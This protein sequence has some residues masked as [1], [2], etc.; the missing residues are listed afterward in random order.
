[1]KRLFARTILGLCVL[2]LSVPMLSAGKPLV[3]VD[4]VKGY[5]IE[6]YSF[7]IDGK[8][9]EFALRDAIVPEEEPVFESEGELVRA[10]EAK[11]QVLDNKRI[12]SDVSYTYELSSY[13][14]NIAYYAV[15]F[16]IVDAFTLLPIPYAKYDN[17]DIGL[18]FGVKL[19]NKNLFGT[20]ADLYM[21]GHISQGD[22]GAN[23]WDNREDYLELSVSSL[24]IGSSSLD[25]SVDYEYTNNS[26]DPGEFSFEVD[27]SDLSL[28]GVSL[29]LAPTGT[30]DLSSDFDTWDPS[31]FTLETTFGPFRQD[32]AL[33]SLYSDLEYTADTDTLYTYGYLK[34]HELALF[35][36]PIVF[37]FSV[38]SSTTLSDGPL[39]YLN[40]GPLLETDLSLP[41]DFT[42]S[43]SAGIFLHY[44]PYEDPLGYFHG[45][46]AS[47]SR[48]DIN[49][50]R[51]FR[52]GFSLSVDFEADIYPQSSYADEQYWQVEW[53]AKWFPFATRHFNP[54]FRA[55]GFVSDI[56]QE[57]LPSD[58][59]E[60]LA[61]YFRGILQSNDMLDADSDTYVAV[62]NMNFT[63]TFV[64]LEGFADTYASPF[65]DIGILN[66]PDD[67]SETLV[68]ATAGAEGYV[69]F[70]KYPGFPIRGS[71]GIN[72][73]DLKETIEDGDSLDHVECEVSI[74]MGL[75]F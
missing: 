3:I 60:E 16:D 18:R 68:V 51:N 49:W 6:S 29:S 25:L 48:S 26:G 17:D 75:F 21:V 23:G 74:G 32:E 14:A 53:E 28:F 20:F 64:D 7:S 42:L 43:V 56:E 30:F 65:V 62:L 73:N 34:Q 45:Y 12:F 38:E 55:I 31:E 63:T 8:T 47:L 70:D 46:E 10:L 54:S 40:A 24:P 71:F 11:K 33:Y 37:K 69:I 1:M 35:S 58:S 4:D 19:Y 50:E 59:D 72:L 27:W 15:H 36:H 61:D 22:G 5:T 52:T 66:D 41:F 13:A 9:K 2:F 39:D 57:F 44:V 67:D